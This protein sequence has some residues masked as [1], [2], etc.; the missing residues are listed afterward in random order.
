MCL[1][2]VW[3]FKNFVYIEHCFHKVIQ[4]FFTTFVRSIMLAHT[5]AYHAC[6]YIVNIFEK[7]KQVFMLSRVEGNGR[8]YKQKVQHINNVHVQLTVHRLWLIVYDRLHRYFRQIVMLIWSLEYWRWQQCLPRKHDTKMKSHIHRSTIPLLF[9]LHGNV[10]IR[11]VRA[12]SK[13]NFEPMLWTEKCDQM[14]N[15]MNN[16]CNTQSTK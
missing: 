6:C 15:K 7:E 11:F 5:C 14:R 12:S 3:E 13:D 1:M 4:L 10:S 9:H 2:C 16:T 8:K